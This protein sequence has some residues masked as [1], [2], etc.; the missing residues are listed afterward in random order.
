MNELDPL[1]GP[2]WG[3]RAIP[4]PGQEQRVKGTEK[5]WVSEGLEAILKVRAAYLSGDDRGG[6]F[7]LQRPA[8]RAGGKNRL[9]PAA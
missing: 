9:K 1:I 3:A 2:A 8:S 5:F 4:R 7:W 6:R